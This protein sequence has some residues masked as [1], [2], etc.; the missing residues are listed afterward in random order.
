[1]LD[2]LLDVW[3]IIPHQHK[4]AHGLTLKGV[5][6]GEVVEHARSIWHAAQ[7]CPQCGAQTDDE[8]IC[9]DCVYEEK[10]PTLQAYMQ[11]RFSIP[12]LLL[13][14]VLTKGGI[15]PAVGKLF[16]EAEWKFSAQD[17]EDYV[18]EQLNRI[19]YSNDPH[20]SDRATMA[21]MMLD[22]WVKPE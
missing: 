21:A 22:G 18:R 6:A 3:A 9:P 8:G 12:E 1:M 2:T 13:T 11:D 10:P 7:V 4:L 14:Y 15:K 17:L 16:L 20:S 19:F 5:C